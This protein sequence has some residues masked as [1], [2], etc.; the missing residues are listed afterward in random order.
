MHVVTSRF[1]EI[2]YMYIKKYRST[3]NLSL[4]YSGELEVYSS[5]LSLTSR[6]RGVVNAMTRPLYP[7][8]RPGTLVQEAGWALG[9]VCAGVENLASTGTRS[10]TRPARSQTQQFVMLVQS[11]P[12]AIRPHCTY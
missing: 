10:R 2:I 5:T 12:C 3:Y 8:E 6:E 4:R 1:D 11:S 7:R 9:P